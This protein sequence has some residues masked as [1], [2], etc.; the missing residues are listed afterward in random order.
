MVTEAV[1]MSDGRIPDQPIVK[2]LI[3]GGCQVQHTRGVIATMHAL[4]AKLHP[5]N[6]ATTNLMLVAEVQAGALPLLTLLPEAGIALPP[7][8]LLDQDGNNIQLV[9]KALQ[10]GVQEYV[11]ASEPAAQRELRARIMAER[12]CSLESQL[13]QSV[14]QSVARPPAPASQPPIQTVAAAPSSDFR[15]DPETH[16]IYVQDKYVR[17]SPVEGRV[18]DM[19]LAKRNRTVTIEELIREA[20]MRSD[21]DMDAGIRLLRPHMMR[22]RNKLQN[23]PRLAHRIVNVRGSGYM[24]I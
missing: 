24:F 4:Q 22:L 21:L 23:A 20:M 18:F 10:M 16:M 6:V 9:I 11:L 14:A 8:L 5:T 1:Y 12:L 19:L 3:E 15:W 7:T 13:P 2:G 17:L